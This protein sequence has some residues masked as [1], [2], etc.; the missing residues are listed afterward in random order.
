MPS[1]PAA[2]LN[3]A[4]NRSFGHGVLLTTVSAVA[5]LLTSPQGASARQLGSA[6]QSSSAATAAAAAAIQSVQQA[7]A[8]TK[9]SMQSLTR[10]TQAVQAMQAVQNA[11]RSAALAGSNNLGADPNHS[12]LQLPNVPDGLG[13]GGLQVAPGVGTDPT[14]WQNADL[15]T[16]SSANGQTTVTIQ[17]TAQK[18]ILTWFNFNVG[19]NTQ[20]YFNQSAGN[21]SAGNNWVALNRVIDPS[22]VPSQIL[23]QI[24]AEG[25]VYLI[26]RNGIIFGGSSQ[27][28]T[29]SLLVSSLP[30]LGEPANLSSMVPGSVAYDTAV[31][32][33]N[34]SFLNNGIAGMG[35]TPILGAQNPFGTTYS[36]ADVQSFG[37]ITVQGGAN[38]TVGN[39]GYALLA[40]PS[41]SNAGTILA[42][43]GQAILAAGMGLA[44]NQ[45]GN[46]ATAWL[47]PVM[48]DLLSH[49]ILTP[50]ATPLFTATNTGLIQATTGNVTLTGGAVTQ[51]GVVEVTTGITRPG[52]IT[53][54]ALD[55]TEGIATSAA[56]RA[57]PVNFASGSVTTILPEENGETTTS[58]S[59][60]NAAF[61]PG[62]VNVTGGSVTFQGGSL[63]DAPGAS[64]SVIAV[65]DS[66][67]T[68]APSDPTV[69]GRLYV[70]NGAVI[71]VSGLADVE[72]PVAAALLTIGP[73]TANDMADSP[74]QRNGFLL[75]R[76]V[77]I[78][79]TLSGI[80]SDG[81]AWVGSPILDAG[82][83]VDGMPRTIDQML[84]N[85][86][87]LSLA[88]GEVIT[89]PGSV[90]NLTGGY[91]H[92]LGGS[93]RTTRLVDAY[94]RLVDIGDADPNIPI[95]GIAGQFTVNHVHWG[96]S[97]TY[98]DSLASG[99]YFEPDYIQGGDAGTLNIFGGA[100][101]NPFNLLG[102]SGAMILDGTI[103]A[104]AEAGLHQVAGAKLPQG[105][106]LSVGDT[107]LAKLVFPFIASGGSAP[108]T[109]QGI[110]ITDSGTQ[111]SGFGADTTLQTPDTLAQSRTDPDNI[112][113]TSRLSAR[114]LDAA[115]F[116]SMSFN[117]STVL[118]V[119]A[120]LVVA[121]GGS[122]KLTGGSV[123][124]DA[125]LTAPGGAISILGTGYLLSQD[126]TGTLP[127]I[128][129]NGDI[130]IGSGAVISAAGRWVNDSGLDAG[131]S[132]G[133]ADID[134]GSI[135]LAT[136]GNSLT[137][138]NR[139]T[140]DL[141]GSIYLLSGSI[142][143][144]SSGGYVG[145]DGRLETSN[146][147][148]VG[149]GGDISLQT[150]VFSAGA[151]GNSGGPNLPDT[152]PVG[153][154]IILDGILRGYGFSGGGTLTLQ[155]LAIQIGGDPALAPAYTL[156][157]P[158]GFFSEGGFSAY[159]LTAVYDATIAAGTK[160][161]VSEQNFIPNVA[162]LLQAPTGTDLYGIGGALPDGSHVTV[163]SLDSYHREA[164]GF[165]L[166]AGSYESWSTTNG[167]GFAAVTYSGITGTLLVDQGAAIVADPG[168]LVALTSYNQLT[169][170]GVIVAHGGAISLTGAPAR[171]SPAGGSVWLGAD[172]V[173][174]ASGVALFNPLIAPARIG[175]DS[176]IPRSGE[177]LDGGSVSVIDGTGYVVAVAGSRIDVSGAAATFDI[178]QPSGGIQGALFAPTPVWSNAGQITLGG[179]GGLLFDGTLVAHGGAPQADGGTLTLSAVQMAGLANSTP[180]S[181]II[182]QQSGDFVLAGLLPG[183]PVTG[184]IPG[185]ERFA[186]DRLG[187]SGID[188]LVVGA[189]P[190]ALVDNVL[191]ATVQTTVPVAIGFAGSV[192]IDLG[193]S[194][195]ADATRY[196]VLAAGATSIPVL[197]EGQTSVGA[198]AVSI[199]APYVDLGGS[200]N[201]A[202]A[203]ATA[204][205]TLS[206]RAGTLDLTGQ[207][208]LQ[209]F[210][211]VSFV[212]SGDI[213]FYTPSLSTTTPDGALVTAGNL[214][215]QAAQ[216]YPATGNTFII[217]AVGPNING[218]R[219][220]TTITLLPNGGSS[221][222]LSAGGSLLF[223]ATNIVQAG[224]I[225]A[226]DGALVLGVS[227][228]VAQAAAFNNLPLV[229]TQSVILA[230]G[231]VTSVSL[232]GIT[233]PYG[234]TVDGVD[235]QYQIYNPANTQ[236]TFPDLTAPPAK[237]ISLGGTSLAL[238]P[239]ATV[240]LSG[241]GTI[242]ASEWIAGSGGSRNLLLRANTTFT[243]ATPTQTPLYADDRPIYAI[244]PGYRGPVAPVDA[245]M[246]P[247]GGAVGSQVY[248]S[249]I[250][251]LPAGTYTLLPAQYATLP[252]AYR[253]VQQTGTVDALVNQNTVLAD[254]SAIVAGAFVD[255]LTGAR[256]SRTTSFLVQSRAVWGQYS[257][258]TVT[259]ANSYF[260]SLA[261]NTGAIAPRLPA[262]AGQLA[263]TA[264][265]SLTLGATLESGAAAGGRGATVDIASQDIQIVGAGEAA[266]V[267][268]VQLDANAL[269]A[270]GAESLLIG[271]TRSFTA[272]GETIAVSANSVVVSNDA[273]HPLTGPEILLVTKTDPT[274]TDP[275]AAV[276]LL[277]ESGSVI[278]SKGSPSG[279]PLPVT[280][281]RNADTTTNTSAINGD[282]ALLA[283][284]NN[285]LLSLTRNDLPV[286][287]RGLLTIEGGVTLSGGQGLT[288]DASGNTIVDPSAVLSGTE[289]AADSGLI[290]F[291]AGSST[292]NL[293]G[294]TLGASTLAQFANAAQ[295][296]LRSY[297]AIDFEGKITID[298]AND[299]TLSAGAFTSG[300][301]GDSGSVS[302][303]AGTL[304]LTN[305][306]SAA[307]PVS[308]ATGSAT[309]MLSAG[310]I[311]F[312]RAGSQVVNTIGFS[313]FGSVTATAINGIVGQG[314]GTFDF[315]ALPVNLI[316]PKIIA[317]AGGA[318]T[319]ETSGALVLNTASAGGATSADMAFGSA[320]TLI[321]GSLQDNT[322]VQAQAGNITLEATGGDLTIASGAVV[323]TAGVTKQF[324][325][326]TA[327]VPAGNII[328]T[329]D[330]GTI[331]IASGAVL[332]F[333]GASDVNGGG[334]AGSL[335]LSAPQQ[336]VD[337]QG[338]L[339]GGA[340][341]RA[342]TQGGSFTLDVGAGV[343]L[344]ALADKL[345]SGGVNHAI[346][347]HTRSGD[348][349]LNAGHTITAT[350][351]ALVADDGNVNINFGASIDASGI[352]GG[353]INLFG[354]SGVDVEGALVA[355][356]TDPTQHGGAIQIGTTGVFDPA[357]IDPAT[358]A[359]NPYNTPYGYENIA[360][361][362]SGTI[363]IGP[364]AKIEVWGGVYGTASGV[365]KIDAANWTFTAQMNLGLS[366][367]QAIEVIDAASGH[368]VTGTVTSYDAAL[369]TLVVSVTNTYGSGFGGT[370]W[371]IANPADSGTILLRAPLLADGT[372][373]VNIASTAAFV[374]PRST[375]LEAYA[376]WSTTDGTTGAQHFD[377]IVD[378]AGW[379]GANGQ[380]LPGTFTKQD[381][382]TV[383]YDGTNLSA[384][385]LTTYLTNDFFIPDTANA[386]H[387]T[388]YGYDS[389]N[390]TPGT[391]MGFIQ[392]GLGSSFGSGFAGIA[393]FQAAPGI[394]LDNTSTAVNGG[395]I[396][397][398]TNW[399]LGAGAVNAGGAYV[400]VY[401]YLGTIAPFL[402][403]RAQNSFQIDAS[404]T[405]GFKIGDEVLPTTPFVPT[406]AT[407][408]QANDAYN[409][410]LGD[411]DFPGSQ[412][413]FD[414]GQTV[415]FGSV[416][417]NYAISGPLANQSGVY[418]SNYL[419]YVTAYQGWLDQY[420]WQ[421]TVGFGSN[422]LD[423][424]FLSVPPSPT[425]FGVYANYV[426]AYQAW[427]TGA[428]AGA[429]SVLTATNYSGY[430]SSY[431]TWLATTFT[432]SFMDSHTA[433]AMSVP[434]DPAN[435]LSYANAYSSA[436]LTYLNGTFNSSGNNSYAY[437]P[438]L[439]ESI[440]AGSAAV[441]G[442]LTGNL[443]SNMPTAATPLALQFATLMGGQST[444]YRIVAGADFGSAN[445][446]AVRVASTLS[447]GG[448]VALDGHFT[449]V[450]PSNN[451]PVSA[452]TTLRTGT[453]SIDIAAAG[454]IV[455]GDTTAP[456]AVYT[457]G[458]PA[459]GAAIDT[460]AVINR[461]PVNNGLQIEYLSNGE[462]HPENAGDI[463]ITA[464]R[465][466]TGIQ[467]VYDTTGDLTGTPGAFAGQ[468][469]W[470]WMETANRADGTASSINFAAFD[471]GVM[472]AGG[473]VTVAAGRDIRELSVS[474][475]T[476][477]Y[478]TG[479]TVTTIGGG[480]LAVTAGRDILSGSY[481]V[482][483]G[484]GTITAGGKIGSDFTISG[485]Y[486]GSVLVTTPVSTLLGYQDAVLT[487]T[488]RQDADIGGV[489]DPSYLHNPLIWLPGSRDSQSPTAR[490]SLS[491]LSVAG[492]AELDTM[493]LPTVLLLGQPSDGVMLP[494][495]LSMT[496]FG[497]RIDIDGGGT[498]Y[499]SETGQ[500][501]LL[502]DSSVTFVDA[503]L[504]A[505]ASQNYF[506]LLDIDPT[507]LPS[508]TN[509][510]ATFVIGPF[511]TL[512]PTGSGIQRFDHVTSHDQDTDPVRIYS[513]S[514]DIVDGAPSAAFGGV[515]VS[516]LILAPNKPAL[517]QAG[518]D[519]SNLSFLGQNFLDS[520]VTRISAG[521]DIYDTQLGLVFGNSLIPVLELAGPGYF[522]IEA[523]RNIGPLTSANEANR[524]FAGSAPSLSL[525]L[526]GIATGIETVGDLYNA[527]LPPRSASITALFGI[528][529]GVNDAGFAAAYI[530]PGAS[531]PG[532]ASLAPGL[533]AYVEQ[534]ETD[535]LTR[536]GQGGKAPPLT[537][538][539]AWAAFQALPQ[540]QQQAFVDQEF[541]AV[542][543]QV[544]ADYNNAASPYYHQYSRGYQAINTLFP[545]AYGYTQNDLDGGANGANQLVSTGT[546]D[547]RGSTVQT[548]EGGDV[549]ILGPGGR[550]LVG[551]VSA[552]PYLVDNTGK[553][554]V[555][556]NQQG[557]L[558][559]ET[560]D[561]N[562]FS[563]QSLLLA[564]S[565]I[566][567]EQGGDMTIWSSN[568]DINAGEGAK[569]SSD[570]PP[571]NYKMNPD[572]YFLLDAKSQ[573]TGAGIATLQTQPEAAPGNVYLIA[574]RGT[575]DAG[576]A[577]IRVSG[578][579]AIAALHVENAFNIQVQ[580]STVG[581]P[582]APTVNIG[583][584]TT[585]SNAT[586]A[587]QQAGLPSQ[588]GNNDR[589]SIIIVEVLGYG[590]GGGE[591]T[592]QN[593]EERRRPR[594]DNHQSQDP[595]NPVQVI[596]AGDL[597]QAQRQKLTVTEIQNFDAR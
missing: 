144:V 243:G 166:T 585:A 120:P 369:G 153:G 338:V 582:V 77:T 381:G 577:G 333:A 564:Q 373:N 99:A 498:L 579:L 43:G 123:R 39:L 345:A 348:L 575:V 471:Q 58:S 155:A 483:K 213:R 129:F 193:R 378:P 251:G 215:F 110:V 339:L 425:S 70:D 580:G 571:P 576:A 547:M 35:T 408:A 566:F 488:A 503:V 47:Y 255:G 202:P 447:G 288:L 22:G 524:I 440:P 250:P 165:S 248:L 231:S 21:T 273:G 184:G 280:I 4:Y 64:L 309:L 532:V 264:A 112:L 357:A 454:D 398:L 478:A 244:I 73:L 298:V 7:A 469:W 29:N 219:L 158:A 209:N 561:V 419:G 38:I 197:A 358:G 395:N 461:S 481:F 301:Q 340:V 494:A 327:Y 420:I 124:V 535:A 254:G 177:V 170:L 427:V 293:F 335:T 314:S 306:F 128:A 238:N 105:G 256:A 230:A 133:S 497:G 336:T 486:Q 438:V 272:T 402:T 115:G 341:A 66:V 555:G 370:A 242:Q 417:P 487:V 390:A 329:A 163:G 484:M 223:D 549:S 386:D 34:A 388:F 25:A 261:A 172:A 584:L 185:V 207:I 544:G 433:P 353:Q 60:A 312:G 592:P 459:P 552:P 168:A 431:G 198:S 281:G 90:L 107:D 490:S 365:P 16:Q 48:T 171:G 482:A 139:A 325:D 445:P 368:Y 356:A 224:T 330:T 186:I 269:D 429:P 595:A 337:L 116:S 565:R 146:G 240:D 409:V 89:A 252:G 143:D 421:N 195:I 65:A 87:K 53:I 259:D 359:P 572:G 491:I 132:T 383:H 324:F 278:A 441:G 141:T 41:V 590:G 442:S 372:V 513:L 399:N 181:A 406:G 291:V 355:F 199:S 100:T 109:T 28:N 148:A 439:P 523:G 311:D 6:G 567:T 586:T 228:P 258:Y 303:H 512:Q 414:L 191:N 458:E 145:R 326:Q 277:V 24:K 539:Q 50:D 305:D 136:R 131:Q 290:T 570:V 526:S 216:L 156:Q 354:K 204:D 531:I 188:S 42:P 86:G 517:V 214:T 323:D 382:T 14:L 443:P 538:D 536:S 237:S 30:F 140:G 23:G 505:G 296:V 430:L 559:L 82:G 522:D 328:L 351:V 360:A 588:S 180:A 448:N 127:P 367:G 94:G 455:W 322:L 492:D 104:G 55:E 10:A 235:W 174:D 376:V 236:A 304:T 157:L 59:A 362:N 463:T 203:L 541:F 422:F 187:G 374:A 162:A 366:S 103:L 563:D 307:P 320:I 79:T 11:A 379:Y 596:G 394:E 401:R 32:A 13:A 266:R 554:I 276:G 546:F 594:S 137:D 453:G 54:T 506:G 274:N 560:G 321:G 349:V 84:V 283:V 332:N 302:I 404:I 364:N 147:I 80:R 159:N 33:S 119:E 135:S 504:G 344:D 91:V 557:I 83:Y 196:V 519:I 466:I 192:S 418:Y 574:P 375:T 452:P 126:S 189:D 495:S 62:A 178:M 217:D 118:A 229:T 434:T 316:A 556:P 548:Q 597:S 499:P 551:S 200:Y 529:N 76:T 334:S 63:I 218:S 416:D 317:G 108:T 117:A 578:D 476:T 315:G 161:T 426:A 587:T 74:L 295:I 134:G 97:E 31:E 111:L 61:V 19:K 265:S 205:G 176:N 396:S 343:D 257:Q 106:S 391:L 377:G 17:Q 245:E 410:A 533:V 485:S 121:P 81:L 20:A 152:Q 75:G 253:V 331:H 400:P 514:G 52:A 371:T 285:G 220:P 71:D 241:G 232:D 101:L 40:A 424:S 212:S 169:D 173:L 287:A 545:A 1:F 470:Q 436:Y 275:Y 472:S 49:T 130:T 313:G 515:N 473:N 479:N 138:G 521:R 102:S 292:P 2:R 437:A 27:I 489:Y 346:S 211:N 154:E 201:V 299:L 460:T 361:T 501:S 167:N 122:I 247:S 384:A 179:T 226:P 511:A 569:T 271:G 389:A 392:N 518:Q 319:L 3:P 225:R 583:A 233:V 44:L 183:N 537:V 467:Q 222:P 589:A 36:L 528:A 446:L 114:L 477:W 413:S 85:A 423:A 37:A 573:V 149:K 387:Q 262:D 500:L 581:A 227:D 510:F 428:Y 525:A 164:A 451:D 260:T 550:I 527:A 553:T 98:T 190:V 403:L 507:T 92:Y 175:S 342:G 543:K 464:G 502:A 462:V 15:P 432:S 457:G 151:F 182:L 534:I 593:E 268:Y 508:P 591:D 113:Y 279:T 18:A 267:G 46:A 496:A 284:S 45:P 480:D 263:L 26:N 210:A 96:V 540:Y 444:S 516:P 72:L 297:G 56:R 493:R 286:S 520:D 347:I 294:M 363:T 246:A 289:I 150:Y 208:A 68:H 206:I 249:G 407:F 308:P 475:P 194:F 5:L 415:A 270:L 509:P 57:G 397:V 125:D 300:A 9:Q 95:V 411:A 350:G 456:A 88:G 93:V 310:E 8:A 221:T 352:A 568:G 435:Y 530:A 405:D 67:Y 562:I 142:L 380:L 160:V 468:T 465:D 234:T 282:G 474:L 385:E 239:G 558:T 393:N 449:W 78:D 318:A 542:L 412:I 450:D 12:G 51:A 69:A